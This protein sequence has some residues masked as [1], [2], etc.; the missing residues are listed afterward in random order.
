VQD[1]TRDHLANERTFLA[2]VRTSLGLITLGFV[3]AR[4]GLFLRQLALETPGISH[5]AASATANANANAH[6]GH[7]YMVVGVVFLIFGA[8]IAGFAAWLHDRNRRAIDL[9]TY[10]PSR[11]TVLGV[12]GAVVTGGLVIAG[13]IVWRTIVTMD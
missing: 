4:M 12:A 5:H 7:E 1:R 11:L 9:E 6:S 10:T 13:M 8:L 2:W 3:L